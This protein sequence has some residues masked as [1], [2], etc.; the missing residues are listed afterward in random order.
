MPATR[1]AETRAVATGT[2]S[3]WMYSFAWP[4]PVFGGVLGACHGIDI[5][6]AFHALDRPG[7]ALFTGTG[8]DRVAIADAFHGAI[9]AFARDG[10]IDWPT[11]EP[12]RRAVQRF[13]TEPILVDDPDPALHAL[14][15]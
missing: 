10:A 11:Y 8:D 6:F 5:P 4:T 12:R 2:S 15:R 1:V 7:V 3:T 13:D 14:Y 9:V